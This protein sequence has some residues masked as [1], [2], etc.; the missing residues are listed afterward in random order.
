MATAA[1]PRPTSEV[2]SRT[3]KAILLSLSL[4]S[5]ISL[6]RDRPP[7]LPARVAC[8]LRFSLKEGSCDQQLSRSRIATSLQRSPFGFSAVHCPNSYLPTPP[9]PSTNSPQNVHG[10]RT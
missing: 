1:S 5:A 9:P 8:R 4:I 6:G 7:A 2:G 3:S 10:R